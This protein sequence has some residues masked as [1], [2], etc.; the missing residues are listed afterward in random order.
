MDNK[1][2]LVAISGGVDSLLSLILLQEQGY[3]VTALHGIFLPEIT[4]EIQNNIDKIEKLCAEFLLPC[5]IK[6]FR[7]TF[8][9]QVT[10]PF[11]ES[12]CK[13]DT[14]NPCAICNRDIKF[15]VF[16]SEA[17]SLG[18]EHLATGHYVQ[19]IEHAEY[20]TVLQRAKDRTKDQSYFLS[21]VP[22][23]NLAKVCFPLAELTKENVRK[24][25]QNRNILAPVTKE[26]Q[27]IC[28]I[29]DD[30]YRRYLRENADFLPSAGDVIL[31]DGKVIGRHLG[32]W[33]YTQGQRK[34]LNI[35]WSEPLFVLDKD[36]INQRLIVGTKDEL[37]SDTCTLENMNYFVEREM[38]PL[39]VYLQTRFREHAKPAFHEEIADSKL[40]F[41]CQESHTTPT[42]GQI[43][44]V[45]TDDGI[46]LAGGI[47]CENK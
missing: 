4:S 6:D 19:R 7:E 23:E 38:W 20:A 35:S 44:A 42:P 8:K 32:L 40:M 34:G 14:P 21:L 16:L 37:P 3:K 36:C 5:I 25:L 1:S 29:P 27:E 24:E 15:G 12:Y 46:L 31:S 39:E 11:I 30:D 45:Y 41:S 18:I 13:G 26:S 17:K 9:K 28:F 33:N 2:I 43:G 47:I 10:I 22:K